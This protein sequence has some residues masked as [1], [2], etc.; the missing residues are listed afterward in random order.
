MLVPRIGICTHECRANRL[1]ANNVQIYY[2]RTIQTRLVEL[3]DDD[4]LQ[5]R[6]RKYAA[7]RRPNAPVSAVSLPTTVRSRERPTS[8][9]STVYNTTSS[10]KRNDNRRRDTDD[11][12]IR[13]LFDR[14]EVAVY[15]RPAENITLH[16]THI[17][18]KRCDVARQTAQ[19]LDDG[20]LVLLLRE[21]RDSSTTDGDDNGC[22]S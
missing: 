16:T 2:R 13:F 4:R 11:Y 6:N 15:L 20:G 21:R 19:T 22:A 1:N 17:T 3:L 10:S 14:K 8:R 9:A 7:A 12:V 5:T 18:P